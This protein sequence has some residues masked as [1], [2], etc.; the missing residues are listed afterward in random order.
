MP[1]M[2]HGQMPPDPYAASWGPADPN[3]LVGQPGDFGAG[4]SGWGMPGGAGMP[5]NSLGMG[6]DMGGL[7]GDELN[8]DYADGSGG[9]GVP[10]PLPEG[11]CVMLPAL[12]LRQ[13]FAS[14]V[15]YGVKQLEVCVSRD[16]PR[17]LS[18][19]TSLT[20]VVPAVLAVAGAQPARSQAAVWPTRAARFASRGAVWLTSRLDSCRDPA[21]T[22]H[23]RGDLVALRAA[24]DARAGPRLHRRHRRRR[25]HVA[26]RLVQRGGAVTAD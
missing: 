3:Q 23:G 6:M 16:H 7:D 25:G 17:S 4:G 24:A 13:P 8:D 22:I 26:S 14:L 20:P 9:V 2:S 21:S 1:P 10:Q 19:P 11:P 15:L 12:S 5:L 18:S